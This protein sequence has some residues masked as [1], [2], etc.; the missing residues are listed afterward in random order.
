MPIVVDVVS[1]EDYQIWLAE[2]KA[3]LQAESALVD[4]VWTQDQLMTKGEDVYL[5]AC[6]GCHQPN[7]EGIKGSFPAIKG[8][9]VATGELDDHISLVLEGKGTMPEFAETQTAVELA[10]VIT[11]QRNAF[12]NDMDDTVQPALI[13]EWLDDLGYDEKE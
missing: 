2:K 13:K 6:A 1:K 3:V 7:G 10:A 11:Y 9:D 8:G 5:S 4:K 12:G